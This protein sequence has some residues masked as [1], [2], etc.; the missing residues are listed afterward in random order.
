MRRRS[1]L[2]HAF[3][4]TGD[5]SGAH[6]CRM[7]VSHL[8]SEQE[9][10]WDKYKGADERDEARTRRA[11]DNEPGFG[12]KMKEMVGNT[13]AILSRADVGAFFKSWSLINVKLVLFARSAEVE[14]VFAA[15]AN[16]FSASAA[17]YQVLHAAHRNK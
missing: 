5:Y 9:E 8:T 1:F 13:I 17:F 14:P 15:V 10:P 7:A 6:P 4:F 11:R 12:G 2:A 3:A 16:V